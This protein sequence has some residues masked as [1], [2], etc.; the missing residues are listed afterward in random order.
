VKEPTARTWISGCVL[1]LVLSLVIDRFMGAQFTLREV[2]KTLSYS[3]V[4]TTL[5]WLF[6]LARFH[7]GI[8]KG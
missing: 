5:G 4:I 3:I 1:T 2:F 6:A 7:R 8:I